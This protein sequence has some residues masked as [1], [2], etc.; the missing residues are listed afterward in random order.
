MAGKGGT[1]IV[2][3]L[4]RPKGMPAMGKSKMGDMGDGEGEDGSAKAEE[5]ALS[6]FFDA[7][8]RGDMAAAHDA[9]KTYM[10]ICYPGIE[11]TY[12]SSEG[13]DKEEP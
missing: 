9:L 10:S 13:S 5:D 2:I 6:E 11:D 7:G 12:H 8:K 1:A 3:G 4:G